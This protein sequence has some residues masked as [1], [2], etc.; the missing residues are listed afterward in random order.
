V[1]S[2][3]ARLLYTKAGSF[4][5]GGRGEERDIS[6]LIYN[7]IISFNFFLARILFRQRFIFGRDLFSAATYFIYFSETSPKATVRCKTGFVVE[8]A[9]KFCLSYKANTFW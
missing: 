9:L 8:T 3:T 6:W 4:Q 1:W 2:K 5:E 7:R